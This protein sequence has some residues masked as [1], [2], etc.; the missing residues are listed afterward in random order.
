MIP[1]RLYYIMV[2]LS[3]VATLVIFCLPAPTAAAENPVDDAA[4]LASVCPVVYPLDQFP[5]ERG[6][7][8][9]FFGNAFFIN[10]KGYLVTAAHILNSFRDGGRPYILVGSPRGPRRLQQAELVAVD[11]EHDVAILRATPNPFVGQHHVAFMSLSSER[12]S[13]GK[14]V[15]AV[16]L[17]PSDPSDS[18]TSEDPTEIRSRGQVVDYQFHAESEGADSELLLFNQKVVPGQSGSPVL[19]ADS[20]E[21]VG[22][23]VGQWLRPTVIHFGAGAK[24]Q[25]VMSPG[26][27]LRIHYV[28]SLL[29]RN[30]ISWHAALV[31]VAPQN[32]APQAG[33]FSPPV[34]ISLVSA[35]YPP[36]ALFGG[37]VVL[38]ARVDTEGKIAELNVVH[39]TAPFLKPVLD[40]VHTWMFSPAKMDGQAAD[41]RIGIVIQFPQSFVPKLAPPEHKYGP[42]SEEVVDHGAL[43][44]FTV[45]PDYPLN[46]TAEDSVIL[47]K[48][49]NREGRVT[50]T[51]I[52]RDVEPFTAA[53][54]EASQKWQFAPG[55]EEGADAYSAVL[56]VV[57]F[58]HP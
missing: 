15:M 30:G 56:I 39:G 38:D 51:E 18:S 24:Q 16:S 53:T 4:L 3:L 5:T 8:Y 55:K 34:P 42:P 47:Y 20:R 21:V 13:P 58:R 26:A 49:V 2:I 22:L 44:V 1:T 37:E 43:P 45:E 33:G 29:R 6:Y 25:L 10:E 52:L 17:L 32:P 28:I 9:F 35:P 50:S 19:S 57:T 41:A 12:P 40:A 27:A 48:L 11:L 54:L 23:V 36:Q 31:P 7:R 46:T 14:P